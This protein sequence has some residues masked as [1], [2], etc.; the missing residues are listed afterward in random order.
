MITYQFH[1]EAADIPAALAQL[2]EKYI[3]AIRLSRW[4][5]LEGNDLG[6]RIDVDTEDFP[7]SIIFKTDIQAVDFIVSMPKVNDNPDLALEEAVRE[8][9]KGNNNPKSIALIA[10]SMAKYLKSKKNKL[11]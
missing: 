3:V 6:G 8:M 11:K 4:Q 10:L 2:T 1:G 9:E 5:D 7:T